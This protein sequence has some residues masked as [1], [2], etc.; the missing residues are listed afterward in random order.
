M[1]VTVNHLGSVQFEIKARQHTIVSDQPAEN[2]GFDE[3]M[4][5]PELLLA[6]LG[7]CAAFYA[8][9]YL[10][11]F[12]LATEG[13]KVRVTAGKQKEPPRLGDFRIELDLPIELSEEHRQGVERAVRHCLVH[14]TLLNPPKIE[15]AIKKAAE[16]GL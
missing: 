16:V 11:K 5:P 9:A 14:N 8:A 12:K 13:T 10:K 2:G 7:S 1:E 3:G 4:T 6:S 15:I